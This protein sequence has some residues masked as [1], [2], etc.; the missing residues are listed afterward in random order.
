MPWRNGSNFT[1]PNSGLVVYYTTTLVPMSYRPNWAVFP[2]VAVPTYSYDAFSRH[3]PILAAALADAVTPDEP[4]DSSIAVTNSASFR[5]GAPVAA[6]S[7]ASAFG[8]F[9]GTAVADATVLP[10]PA[11]LSGTRVL[12]NGAAARLIAVRPGQINFQVPWATAAG[13]ASVQVVE[14]GNAIAIGTMSVVA[15]APGLFSTDLLDPARPGAVLNQDF[16]LNS[17]TK[18]A[19]GGDYIQI[20]GTGQGATNPTVD[21]GTAGPGDPY[22][23]SVSDAR[24]YIGAVGTEV[25]FSG[26]ST[27]SPGLWQLNV[28]VPAGLSAARILCSWRSA[29]RPATVSRCGLLHSAMTASD[30]RSRGAKGRL[31][32]SGSP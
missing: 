8:D 9:N 3:D 12:V 23:R 31:N 26:L 5:P 30:G 11:E 21:D 32:A 20:Y 1:L 16:S 17:D 29:A 28:K 19:H 13:E 6:G 24:I 7:L 2:D 25:Q 27:Q 18:P 22:A 10:L 15:V 4:R 14:G